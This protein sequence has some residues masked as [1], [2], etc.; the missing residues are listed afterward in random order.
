MVNK[1][2]IES[3]G[4]NEVR[5][6]VVMDGRLYTFQ[7]INEHMQW[8]FKAYDESLIGD[9]HLVHLIFREIVKHKKV[10]AKLE[11]LKVDPK[12]INFELVQPAFGLSK[13]Y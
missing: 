1:V 7:L 5:F 8:T 3:H 10:K 11:D 2:L 13:P 9:I 4:E 12:D 6:A